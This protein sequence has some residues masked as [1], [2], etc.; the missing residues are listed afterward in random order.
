MKKVPLLPDRYEGEHLEEPHERTSDGT[1]RAVR[2]VKNFARTMQ[3]LAERGSA[4]SVVSDQVGRLTFTRDLAEAIV[5]R[6]NA[7]APWREGR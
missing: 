1:A 5:H 6:R 2:G 4:P 3:Q 7:D